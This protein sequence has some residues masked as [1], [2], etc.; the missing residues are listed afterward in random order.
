MTPR[1]K[2]NQSK[3]DSPE[4]PHDTRGGSAPSPLFRLLIHFLKPSVLAA[5]V[6]IVLG[7]ICYSNTFDAQFYFDDLKSIVDNL[8]IRDLGNLRAIWK[9]SPIRFITYLSFAVNYHFGELNVFGYHLVNIL[10]HITAAYFVYLFTLYLSILSNKQTPYWIAVFAALIFLCHPIQTQAVTY[11][12]QR[13]ASLATLFYMISLTCY[14]RARI[15]F[16][17]FSIQRSDKMQLFGSQYILVS[18]KAMATARPFLGH[19]GSL[20]GLG[21]P[22]N[23]YQG[24]RVHPACFD[25]PD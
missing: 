7:L 23:V 1:R 10:I 15:L 19:T 6:I 17:G 8:S 22:G 4:H 13:A 11:I 3:H 16:E 2:K 9:F 18:E 21:P 5:I 20:G 14:V 25:R 12:V 24:N